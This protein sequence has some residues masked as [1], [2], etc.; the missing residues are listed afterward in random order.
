MTARS[1]V[2]LTMAQALVRFLTA[3]CTSRDGGEQPFFAGV[4][5]IF[6][7]GNVAGIGQALQ[8]TR[9]TLRYYQARNEQAMVHTA[10]A[11]AK[12]H[13]RLRTLACTSSIGPGATN[14]I[15]GAAGR[16]HQPAAGAAAAGR[17]L[18]EPARRRRSCSSSSRRTS[19]DISVNDCFKPVS[20][21]WDRITRPEQL[22]TALPEAMR[23]LTSPADTGAVTLAL[24]QDVQAEAYDY[25][26][27]AVRAARLDDSARARRSR[28]P[29]GGRAADPREQRADRSSRAAACIYSEATEA[30]GRFVDATGIPVAETQAGKGALPEPHPL[31]LGGIGATGT[32]RREPAGAR[33][34]PRHRRRHAPVRFHDGIEDARSSTRVRFI[35]INV[36]E[37]DAFKHGALPLVGD[38][39]AVLE[40]LAPLVAGYRVNSEYAAAIARF[41]AEWQAEVARVTAPTPTGE[42]AAD[43]AGSGHRRC[44]RPRSRQPTSSS[45]RPAACPATCTSCGGPAIRR[46]TTSSTAIRAWDMRSPAASA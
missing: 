9:D 12:M 14:M 1:T 5:G 16:D 37:I 7:H 26:G 23:V 34:R 20:R 21:Y 2:R 11:Y 13:N 44:Q 29:A 25:P 28:T 42:K 45:A 24:P 41:Q 35:G 19:Q 27:G 6:G 32:Q 46:A 8:Q 39:R 40:E 17:H 22:V 10:A 4:F 18:R 3:Q 31:A 38:A 30:L 43:H 33:C 36:A 15:T